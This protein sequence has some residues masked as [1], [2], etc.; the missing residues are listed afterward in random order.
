MPG[1][2]LRVTSPAFMRLKI[3]VSWLYE[4]RDSKTNFSRPGSITCGVNGENCRPFHHRTFAFRC[5]ATCQ[6]TIISTPETIGGREINYQNVVVGGS[7]QLN[8]AK[9]PTYRGDSFICAAAI[10]AGLLDGR[11]GGSGIVSLIGEQKNFPSVESN[12]ISS[13]EFGPSFPVAFSFPEGGENTEIKTSC[14]DPRWVVLAISV[15]C[16]SL[17]SIF[18]V[19]PA[20]FFGSV[21]VGVY[22]TVALALDSP[23]FE[24]YYSVIS[25]AFGGLL[26]AVFV[27]LVIYYFCVS[28]TLRNLTAQFERTVLW[29]GACWMGALD[30]FTLERLPIQ[31]LTPHD[32]QQPGALNTL[33]VIVVLIVA[34]ALSQAWAFS[35]EGRMLRYLTFYAL[36]GVFLLT[37]TTIPHMNLRLHHY[38]IAL[39]LLPGTA[40]QTRPSLIY[41]GFL[42]GLFL[43]GIARWG[44][45]SILQTPGELFGDELNSIVPQITTPIID[46]NNITFLW[47]NLTSAF[48]SISV[49]VNDVERFRGYADH[50][51]GSF[52]WTR[53]K[54]DEPE[55]F[56]FG[57]IRYPKMWGSI[58][59]DYT[60]HATW[61]TNGTWFP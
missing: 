11:Y 33:I 38:V 55:F 34:I 6:A 8:H 26:P 5:P 20:V 44:F 43:N 14:K 60:Q 46:G 18:T 61:A 19:S 23:D 28:H 9:V 22:L 52:S 30:N 1:R 15:I 59:G 48:D 2:W 53:Y 7:M 50:T 36:L 24:D 25:Q 3:L 16:T 37:L 57:Y 51:S 4:V 56:R 54:A 39:I 12:G 13:I 27:G 29:L 21:F 35:T 40:L 42:V 47:A 45:D 58:I 31:R 10:H 17:L 32:L 41:Q 49:L